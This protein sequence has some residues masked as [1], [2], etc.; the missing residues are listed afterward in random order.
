MGGSIAILATD[1]KAAWRSQVGIP[2]R[3]LWVLLV[4]AAE[5]A[6]FLDPLAVEAEDA[7]ELPDVVARLLVHVVE[8]RLRRNLSRAYRARGAVL[9]RVRGRIDWLETESKLHLQ[10]GAIACRFEELTVDTPRNRLVRA[11]LQA[12]APFVAD[13]EL[14]R[15]CTVLARDLGL[16]G[17]NE[18]RPSRTE[19]AREQIARHEADDRLMVKVA[20]L[21]LDHVLPSELE[22]GHLATGLD[23]RETA[24]RRIFEKA[25]AGFYRHELRASNGWTIQAQ[26]EL[27]WE[28]EDPT[29]SLQPLLPRMATDVVLTHASGRCIVLDTK[30]TNILTPRQYGGHGFKSQHLYQ[31]YSYLRSQVGRGDAVADG[32][33]GLLLHPAVDLAVDEAVTIQGHRIRFAT[34][35]LTE[36]PDRIRQQLLQLALEPR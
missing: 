4:Y 6:E 33:E 31:L 17:V 16:L 29:P 21:A 7:A 26:R 36:P 34:V 15:R 23:R 18:G 13:R 1:K 9:T 28:I 2:V 27:N 32:A 25:V 22:G 8:R 12:S 35:D 10:R 20:E 30:F 11:A 19:M 24:L 14:A 3:S 5:L